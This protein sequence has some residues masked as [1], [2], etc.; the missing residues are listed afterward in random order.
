M[1]SFEQAL[2]KIL[3]LADKIDFEEVKLEES[4]SRVLAHD[5]ISSRDQPPFD[6]SAM[7]GYALNKI[8]KLPSK[9]LSIIGKVAA[10]NSFEGTV[11]KGQAVRV[12][13]GAPMPKGTNSVLIQEDA[14]ELEN[15]ITINQIVEKKDFV[16]KKGCDYKS[17]EI[18]LQKGKI[19][20]S[21]D[22]ALL[23]SM[24]F[25]LLKVTK[26]PRV[27]II[28]TGDELVFPGNLPDSNQI[29]ASNT[30]GLKALLTKWG[31]TSHILPIA[32]DN[33]SSLEKAIDLAIPA[34]LVITIGGASVGDH[35]YVNKV[36]NK[37]NVKHSF[38]KVAMRPGK[39]ILAGKNNNT[40]FV[41][42]PGN[43]VSALVCAQLLL[44]PLIGK[45]L[46]T[47]ELNNIEKK[48]SLQNDLPKNGGRKHFMR[49]F[50]NN[51]Y[52]EVSQKQDSSLLNVLQKANALVIRK[53]N[54]PPA[55]KGDL[56][57]YLDLD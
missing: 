16:R 32:R 28:S 36:F 31:A 42:L 55:K 49:A 1:I 2:S 34:D 29:V 15:F 40:I 54:E 11:G 8:D 46:G 22:I 5:S 37:I 18:L 45:M 19:L 14:E 13:T 56:I 39:P 20:T 48:A 3:Y 30:Y 17:G 57:S 26:Q 9:K 47:S 51:G 24:N 7:D 52:L 38:Y 6:A 21:F 25:P 4:Y 23:A 44:K 35:D 10:G 41:G 53:P 12:F 27:S 50:F 43:P 33:I